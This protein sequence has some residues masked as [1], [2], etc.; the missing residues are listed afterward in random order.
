MRLSAVLAPITAAALASIASAGVNLIRFDVNGA[1]TNANGP[2]AGVA[3]TG[4]LAVS[5]DASTN[6]IGAAINGA[7]VVPSGTISSLA[8]LITISAGASTGGSFLLVLDQGET[9]TGVL[10]GGGTVFPQAGEGFSVDSL[11]LSATFSNLVNGTHFGGV[12]VGQFG[13]NFVGSFLL[14]AYGPDAN[15]LDDS[16]NVEIFLDV[17]TPGALT[18]ASL[19]GLISSKRHR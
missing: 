14:S 11:V 16:T 18:L 19:A 7:P 8:S 13:L 4:D 1:T 10:S 9:L 5:N 3:H 12:N 15:G 17:P 2:F 6:F